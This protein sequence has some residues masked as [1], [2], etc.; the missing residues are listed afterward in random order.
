LELIYYGIIF[1]DSKTKVGPGLIVEIL[2]FFVFY[3]GANCMD[4][5]DRH[6]TVRVTSKEMYLQLNMYKSFNVI[7]FIECCIVGN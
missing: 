3:C 2:C 6:V 5:T 1:Y 7:S 4:C